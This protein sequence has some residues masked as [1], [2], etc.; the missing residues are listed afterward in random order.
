M[1]EV[2]RVVR[3]IR[4]LSFL[5]A[6]RRSSVIRRT[7]WNVRSERDQSGAG[8]SHAADRPRAPRDELGRSRTSAAWRC[9]AMGA[10]I[11]QGAASPALPRS[12]SAG[13]ARR[14]FRAPIQLPPQ[15]LLRESA[16]ECS[17]SSGPP[18]RGALAQ[19]CARAAGEA[20]TLRSGRTVVQLES[21]AAALS[22]SR[23]ASW[24]ASYPLRR[25]AAH[26][27]SGRERLEPIQKT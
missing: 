5:L 16:L 14:N 19:S 27:G 3:A 20:P 23:T 10:E 9:P 11:V 25:T 18:D 13:R 22:S 15:L 26:S 24:N 4:A 6:A 1:E 8:R 12:F 7:V 21:G 17:R 2:L